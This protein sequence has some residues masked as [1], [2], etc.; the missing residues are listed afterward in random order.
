MNDELSIEF[1]KTPAELVFNLDIDYSC[2]RVLH[3][4]ALKHIDFATNKIKKF[5]ITELAKDLGMSRAG[6][7]KSLKYLKDNN[8][9]RTLGEV[10]Y[11]NP[12]YCYRDSMQKRLDSISFVCDPS[13]LEAFR[14]K[15]FYFAGVKPAKEEDA[16]QY[17]RDHP[18]DHPMEDIW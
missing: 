1:V 8:L 11:V 9:I 10:D 17:Y 15:A 6:L 13:P 3:A 2:V 12:V 4:I 16:E 18:I 14:T 7:Y 5:K